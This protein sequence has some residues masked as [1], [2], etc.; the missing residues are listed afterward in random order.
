MTMRKF[1][2]KVLAVFMALLLT[3]LPTFALDIMSATSS[4]AAIDELVNFDENSLLN[5]FNEIAELTALISNAN[6]SA[7]EIE[8]D[9]LANVD[10]ENVTLPD[11]EGEEKV[12]SGPPLGIPSFLWG[13]V[14]AGCFPVLGLGGIALVY[15]MSDSKDET[16]KAVFGCLAGTAAYVIATLIYSYSVGGSYSYYYGY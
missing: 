4:D 9:V 13:C 11:E 6:V 15:F 14:P 5:E 1:T 10:L 8:A 7:I 3:N 12:E 2:F 16:K